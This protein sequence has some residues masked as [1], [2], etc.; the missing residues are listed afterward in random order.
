MLQYRS[1]TDM[2]AYALHR[3]A[4]DGDLT[5]LKENIERMGEGRTEK[6]DTWGLTPLHTSIMACQIDCFKTLLDWPGTDVESKCQGSPVPHVILTVSSLASNIEFGLQA[7]TAL[8]ER[9]AEST[10]LTESKDEYDRTPLRLACEL[11]LEVEFIRLLLSAYD[12][13]VDIELR[14]QM[15]ACCDRIKKWNA[16]HAAAD[17]SN[18]ARREEITTELLNRGGFSDVVNYFDSCS[19]TS[20]HVLVRRT[21]FYSEADTCCALLLTAGVNREFKD[22]LGREAKDYVRRRTGASRGRRGETLIYSHEVCSKHFTALESDT[23]KP[24]YSKKDI[25]PENVNRLL[26]LLNERFGTLRSRRL[27]ESSR[28]D[29]NPPKAELGDVLRVHDWG[30]IMDFKSRC[31]R[32]PDGILGELDGDTTFSSKTFEAS[33]IACGSVI[34]A[35]DQILAGKCE[36]A[37]CAVRPPGHHAGPAGVVPACTSHGFCFLNTVAVGAGYA[38]DRHRDKIKRIAII[39]RLLFFWFLETKHLHTYYI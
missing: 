9:K 30:Y 17:L 14:K 3:A 21:G 35:I 26:V 11:G 31:Q 27:V 22:V 38:L 36:N 29:S 13:I 28:H 7:L 32:L 1:F 10:L 6:R 15:L 23:L 18:A 4:E 24:Y 2:D 20:L 8:L 12:S 37:F 16:L 25:P 5:R 33:L 39:G 34:Q 19:R